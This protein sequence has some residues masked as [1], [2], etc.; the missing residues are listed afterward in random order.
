MKRSLTLAIMVALTMASAVWAGDT[1]SYG[2]GVTLDKAT[3]I[4]ELLDH[5]EKYAGEKVRIDGVVTAVCQKRGC[6]M[7]ITDADTG[8]GIRIKVEDGVIVFPA[9]A[10]GHEASAEGV[11]EMLPAPVQQQREEAR[12]RAEGEKEGDCDSAK[13]EKAAERHS[14]QHAHGDKILLIRGTGAIIS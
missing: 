13:K 2:D 6:W 9:T 10:V 12:H 4:V 14:C 5:P 7:Q 3:A 8:K 1:T 11:F